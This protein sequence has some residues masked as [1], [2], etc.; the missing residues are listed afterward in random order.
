MNIH[1]KDFNTLALALSAAVQD[2]CSRKSEF[3]FRNGN[4]DAILTLKDLGKQLLALSD[5]ISKHPTLF[6]ITLDELRDINHPLFLIYQCECVFNAVFGYDF[7]KED[8]GWFFPRRVEFSSYDKQYAY[9]VITWH[10]SDVLWV[11]IDGD[12]IFRGNLRDG[13]SRIGTLADLAEK[14]PIPVGRKRSK[15]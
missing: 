6:C 4:C 7:Y 2:L 3:P 11:G 15:K 14:F 9:Q 12:K 13:V 10:R 5:V 8:F 1:I